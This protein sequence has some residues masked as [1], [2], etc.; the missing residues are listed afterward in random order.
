MGCASAHPR[1]PSGANADYSIIR[2]G[3]ESV[4]LYE[5]HHT[6][7]IRFR[8]LR[9][10]EGTFADRSKDLRAWLINEACA[11][12]ADAV[13]SVSETM[14]SDEQGLPV[15][16]IRGTAIAVDVAAPDPTADETS[17]GTP[18]TAPRA[19]DATDPARH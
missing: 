5:P 19:P 13:T 17:P 3:C 11:L 18:A 2:S 12:G 9:V 6:V 14:D 7:D 15:Y 8:T 1:E 4:R 16:K 10:L